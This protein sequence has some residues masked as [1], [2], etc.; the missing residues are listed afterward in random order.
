M[1]IAKVFA[2]TLVALCVATS[3]A[4]T[5]T[6]WVEKNTRLGDTRMT[7]FASNARW[8]LS[9]SRVP[10][11]AHTSLWLFLGNVLRGST[12]AI[13]SY[14]HDSDWMLV[15][16][17]NGEGKLTL[18]SPGSLWNR[19]GSYEFFFSEKRTTGW[20]GSH[21]QFRIKQPEAINDGERV[22]L[23][24]TERL[25]VNLIDE[26]GAWP[27]SWLG[28]YIR[29]AAHPST[30]E[31]VRLAFYAEGLHAG[32]WVHGN[33]GQPQRSFVVELDLKPLKDVYAELDR[34]IATGELDGTSSYP[35]VDPSEARSELLER[36]AR[37]R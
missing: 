26:R 35:A 32:G 13:K 20:T 22:T 34:C 9:R 12:S 5:F 4:E 33:M 2:I 6:Y 23:T 15:D 14:E 30:A 25:I 8:Q 11:D 27:R 16:G 36:R 37:D 7:C 19:N 18:D 10:G 17:P 28:T 3:S 21:Q 1:R 31:F 29:N 24:K